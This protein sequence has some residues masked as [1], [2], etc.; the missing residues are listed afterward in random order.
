MLVDREGFARNDEHGLE[1]ALALQHEQQRK[2]R[3]QYVRV[4]QRNISPHRRWAWNR[5]RQGDVGPDISPYNYQSVMHL[6]ASGR[7]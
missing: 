7:P 2:D 4:F 6:W 5:N 1:H 3:D